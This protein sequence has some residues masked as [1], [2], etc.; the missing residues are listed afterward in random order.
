MPAPYQIGNIRLEEGVLKN[1]D[2]TYKAFLDYPLTIESKFSSPFVETKWVFQAP[3]STT[4]AM[5]LL[6]R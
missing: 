1:A 4:G 2:D 6:L 3:N 5:Q